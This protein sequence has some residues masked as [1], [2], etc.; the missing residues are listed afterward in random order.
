MSYESKGCSVFDTQ[1][2]LCACKTLFH[3]Y[4]AKHFVFLFTTF[5]VVTAVCLRE[6]L[7][8]VSYLQSKHMSVQDTAVT[9]AYMYHSGTWK[10]DCGLRQ[11]MHTELHW[12]DVPERVKYKLGVITRRCLYGSAPR[13]L[14]VCRN[15]VSRQ[16]LR[17][18]T[19]HQLVIPSH[20][21]T[22]CRG[23]FFSSRSDVLE[24]AAQKLAWP[25]VTYCCCF[26]T[27]TKTFLFSE[28]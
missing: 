13:Y 11:L 28:Y 10:F 23:A 4:Y 5:S 21:L 14:A 15:P 3:F 12:P 18:A 2:I 24:L 8:L 9:T 7:K 25:G 20:R 6:L 16:H 1:C 22:T 19:G 26:W 27:I 17:S